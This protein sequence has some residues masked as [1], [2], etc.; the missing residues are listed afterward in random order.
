MSL[1]SNLQEFFYQ[2]EGDM[3][4]KVHHND[5]FKDIPIKEGEVF[6][7]PARVPHSPQRFPNTVGLVIEKQRLPGQLDTLRWYCDNTACRAI[8]Y[9]ETFQVRTTTFPSQT[10]WLGMSFDFTHVFSFQLEDLDLGKA[11]AVII[12]KFYGSVDLRTCKKCGHLC[13]PPTACAQP[14]SM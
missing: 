11:L 6:L 10:Q 8:V 5:Q 7:L 12:N 9:E 3:I 1:L 13:I 4:L 2:L 14:S